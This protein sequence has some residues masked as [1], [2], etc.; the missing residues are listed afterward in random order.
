M[1]EKTINKIHYTPHYLKAYSKLNQEIQEAQ[2]KK[3]KW[4]RQNAFDPRLETH[5][6]K[7]KHRK[8]YSYS[9]TRSF[10]VLFRFVNHDQAIFYDIDTHDIYR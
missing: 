2:D 6:L 1:A 5:K 8:F 9:V 4:F 10:R 3:E 7:G